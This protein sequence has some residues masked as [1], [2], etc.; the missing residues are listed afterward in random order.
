MLMGQ[1]M[2]S[3]SIPCVA[4]KSMLPLGWQAWCE[5]VE[6]S[7]DAWG[8]AS[9]PPGWELVPCSCPSPW[10]GCSRTCALAP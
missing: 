5:Q 2:S 3:G 7:R 10:L 8:Q 4:R 1:R 6:A 9:V